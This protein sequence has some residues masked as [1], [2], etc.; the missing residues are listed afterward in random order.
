MATFQRWASNE[1]FVTNLLIQSIGKRMLKVCQ[2]L[3]K[4]QTAAPF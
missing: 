1:D 3:A 2:R 4:M